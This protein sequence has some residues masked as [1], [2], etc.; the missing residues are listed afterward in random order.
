MVG[1]PGGSQRKHANNLLLITCGARSCLSEVVGH[2]SQFT[3]TNCLQ[4]LSSHVVIHDE[5][6]KHLKYVA[7]VLGLLSLIVSIPKY[8]SQYV[9]FAEC[10]NKAPQIW[11]IHVRQGLWR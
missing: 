6:N 11:G 2:I 4:E 8:R 10:H 9:L 7:P 1:K 3:L 5:W